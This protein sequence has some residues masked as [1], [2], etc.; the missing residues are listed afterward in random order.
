MTY[1]HG[2]Q[3]FCIRAIRKTELISPAQLAPRRRHF[4]R[5]L[6]A[7]P[8]LNYGAHRYILRVVLLDRHLLSRKLCRLDEG[9]VY[10]AP[11]VRLDV[12]VA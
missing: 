9:F 5:P 7:I 12:V 3:T 1:P 2:S 8:A 10:R 11:D 4:P 6:N